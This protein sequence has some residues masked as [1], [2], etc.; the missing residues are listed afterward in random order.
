MQYDTLSTYIELSSGLHVPEAI[1]RESARKMVNP[2]PTCIDLFSGVGGMSLGVIE[3]GFE[4]VCAVEADAISAIT[5]LNNL[6]QW[7]MDIKFTSRKWYRI[8]EKELEREWKRSAKKDELVTMPVAGAH[9]PPERTPVR[10]F[11]FGDVREV[12]GDM[13]AEVCGVPIGELDLMCGGPPC[14]SF[15][16]SGKRRIE[17]PR[18]QLVFEMARL[19]NEMRPKTICF[20]NVP[21]IL[22]MTT[23]EGMPVVDQLCRTLE[24]GGFASYEA[25]CRMF[26]ANPDM[27]A[28][29]RGGK[30]GQKRYKGKEKEPEDE[31]EESA[32]FE[33]EL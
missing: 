18:G 8:F 32:Q 5:Y 31:A 3:A 2:L 6:G 24:A 29:M 13:L 22:T 19:I 23:P 12:T 20:E 10:T 26:S 15:S 9:R 4:V 14:Q 28:A 21:G 11:L 33:M 27:A 30:F 7:P 17:D 16:T 1:A 25:L